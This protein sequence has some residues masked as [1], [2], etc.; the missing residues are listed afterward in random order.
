VRT[1]RISQSHSIGVFLPVTGLFCFFSQPKRARA[2][3]HPSKHC[4]ISW[5]KRC[6][7]AIV[8]LPTRIDER[9]Q[10]D[11]R[12]HHCEIKL[13]QNPD[14]AADRRNRHPHCHRL[15][16]RMQNLQDC[17]STSST[18]T[19]TGT[20][21]ASSSVSVVSTGSAAP[22]TRNLALSLFCKG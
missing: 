16:Q 9:T 14:D 6:F 11:W 15:H 1:T 2:L 12:G 20:R 17:D 7:L 4:L 13:E 19:S 22:A 10:L 5:H 3:R 8:Q 18:T 21:C